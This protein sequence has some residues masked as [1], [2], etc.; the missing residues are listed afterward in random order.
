MD[1]GRLAAA[2]LVPVIRR[3]LQLDVARRADL[4]HR[5]RIVEA[6]VE[7]GLLGEVVLEVLDPG[8]VG[9][10]IGVEGVIPGL[11]RVC[12]VPEPLDEGGARRRH[13]GEHVRSDLA[14]LLLEHHLLQDG[15]DVEESTCRLDIGSTSGS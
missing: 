4:H 12:D 7:R 8:T 15:N 5:Q 2:H 10:E 1:L 9:E 6:R 13:V 3:D 14:L 11:V